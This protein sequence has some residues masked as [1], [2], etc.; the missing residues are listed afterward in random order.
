MAKRYVGTKRIGLGT[1]SLET[2]STG[3]VSEPSELATG[4][5]SAY[6]PHIKIICGVFKPVNN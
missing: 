3:K 2:V 5:T 6:R 1:I 4:R